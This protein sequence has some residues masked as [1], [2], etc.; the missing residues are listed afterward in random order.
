MFRHLLCGD[1][2]ELPILHISEIKTFPLK[3]LKGTTVPSEK[4]ILKCSV[5]IS[6]GFVSPRVLFMN[7]GNCLT[8]LENWGPI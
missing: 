6:S 1:K 8:E 3:P 7:I 2:K 4:E 5:S